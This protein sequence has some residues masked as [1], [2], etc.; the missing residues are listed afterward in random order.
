MIEDYR[1]KL[2]LSDHGYIK[3]IA[4]TSLRNA[5]DL[6]IKEDDAIVME[7]EGTNK[8]EIL[9]FSDKANCYKVKGFEL[10]DTKPSE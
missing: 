2:F 9:F 5:G 10:P 1:L 3:K 8:S 7:L 6:K 4:L